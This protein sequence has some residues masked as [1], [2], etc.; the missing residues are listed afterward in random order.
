[1]KLSRSKTSLKNLTE[2]IR[3]L[4]KTTADG[5]PRADLSKFLKHSEKYKTVASLLDEKGNVLDLP[6]VVPQSV[7]SSEKRISMADV[8]TDMSLTQG[9]WDSDLTIE[10]KAASTR[11]KAR[12]PDVPGG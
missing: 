8:L 5:P 11:R 12:K 4:H 10:A 3:K 2:S 7:T 1:M 9:Y 6:N